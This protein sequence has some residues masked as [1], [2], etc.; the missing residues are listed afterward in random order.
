MKISVFAVPCLA[1]F[2]L[3]AMAQ[4]P[5][6]VGIINIQSAVISTKDGQKAATEL[7]AR[8]APKQKDLERKQGE[9][10]ALRDQLNKS[11]NVASEE[12][13]LKLTR[14]IDQKT[15]SFNREVEDVQAELSQEEGKLMN[16]LGGK[17]MQILDKYAK[18]NGYALVLDVSSQQSPVLFAANGID[19]TQDIIKLY[20]QNSAVSAPAPAS[21]TGTP[22]A[23]P[24]PAATRP[25]AARPT[26]APARTAP[27]QPGQTA[28]APAPR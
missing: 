25:P 11:G 19:V 15:K 28:P 10:A 1:L 18:E 4:S 17:M 7:Q 23:A 21:G 6:K 9:I 8:S 14:E 20:D 22:A 16:E 27:R 24:T 13:K 2:A 3:A 5:T 12:Q 26:I